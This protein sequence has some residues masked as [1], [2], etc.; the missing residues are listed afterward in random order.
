[1]RILQTHASRKPQSAFTSTRGVQS[2]A[3]WSCTGSGCRCVCCRGL[4]GVPQPLWSGTSAQLASQPPAVF[5]P[6]STTPF[7]SGLHPPPVALAMGGPQPLSLPAAERSQLPAWLFPGPRA[8]DSL[9]PDHAEAGLPEARDA[10]AWA[11]EGRLGQPCSSF[12]FCCL[13]PAT[14]ICRNPCCNIS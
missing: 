9:P 2:E 13:M 1:M 3:A 5:V 12:A 6:L 14:I 8:G 10:G 11:L 4:S 7:L